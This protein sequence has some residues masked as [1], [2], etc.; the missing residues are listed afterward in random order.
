MFEKKLK[1][2]INRLKYDNF[3]EEDSIKLIYMF[4]V[5]QQ[6]SRDGID[7]NCDMQRTIYIWKKLSEE[8]KVFKLFNSYIDFSKL[9]KKSFDEIIIFISEEKK[10]PK[11]FSVL[12]EFVNNRFEYMFSSQLA[13]FSVKLLNTNCQ[14]VYAPF[15]N[16]FNIAYYTDKKIFA[17]SH[18]DELF[19]EI[20]KILDSLDIEFHRTD[21][22]KK[23]SYIQ[24]NK[25]KVFDCTVSF[26]PF[27]VKSQKLTF[28][29][30]FFYRFKFFRGK[31]SLDVAYFEHILAQTK[32]KAV[33]LMPTGFTFRGGVEE[34]FR[35][36]LIDN[37][38]LEAI[39][40]LPAN[41]LI[42]T[43]VET[44][45]VIINKVKRN[46]NVYFL[47]LRDKQFITK[48]G[49]QHI[50]NNIEKI[51]TIY[52]LFKEI[53]GISTIVTTSKVKENNYSFSI[54]RYVISKEIL[55]TIKTLAKYET[56]Q[57]QDIA[58]IKK[59]QLIKDEGK[60]TLIYE[61]SPSDFKPFGFTFECGRVKKIQQQYN[62]YETYKLLP[63][64]ILIGTKGTV[65]K[66]AIIGDIK[67]PMVASQAIQVIRVKNKFI[68]NPKVL[69][70]FLKSNIGQALLKQLSTGTIMPQITTK[71]IKELKIPILNIDK[72]K[73]VIHSFEYEAKLYKEIELLEKKIHKISNNFFGDDTNE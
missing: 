55:E 63:N 20:I 65:G 11:L 32:Q 48:K 4:K 31:G 7:T 44:T 15:N 66:I 10:F 5:W 36:Y 25:L 42:G 54:D 16:S 1:L 30:D 71:E 47:N 60:G 26:P 72:Q 57:L 69:Y 70:M 18:I 12:G 27:V 24:N 35:Q 39:V 23:P 38:L 43:G 68:V 73:E 45:F 51:I 14:T 34:K 67:K 50:L 2:L 21:V 19:I 46:S 13:E 62:K 52:K 59:S 37:N 56:K 53:D 17:E 41:I 22:L 49:R 6:L 9:S 3:S 58:S 64:D 61:I 40:Q 29:D 28:E 8:F 33:I